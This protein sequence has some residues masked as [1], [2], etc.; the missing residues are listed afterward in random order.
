MTITLDQ[1]D[2]YCKKNDY[3]AED[4]RCAH[5]ILTG[6]VVKVILIRFCGSPCN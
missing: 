4:P 2:D 6:R 3:D 1:E 5:V